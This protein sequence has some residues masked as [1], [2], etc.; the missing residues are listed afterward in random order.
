MFRAGIALVAS[1]ILVPSAVAD[2]AATSAFDYLEQVEAQFDGLV[3]ERVVQR[4][5]RGR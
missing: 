2:D 3:N 1:M 5:K 4:V